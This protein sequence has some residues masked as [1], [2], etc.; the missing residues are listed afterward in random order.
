MPKIQIQALFVLKKLKSEFK[1][2]KAIY[3]KKRHFKWF[4]PR[5]FESK[6]IDK[7]CN[8]R[9]NELNL[10][11]EGAELQNICFSAAPNRRVMGEK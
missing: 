9:L 3:A 8:M 10:V 6:K 11:F 2:F 1:L 7:K 5:F 4:K